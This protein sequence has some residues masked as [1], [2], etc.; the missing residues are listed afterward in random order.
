MNRFDMAALT[1]DEKP[2]RVNLA[3]N[4]AEK[5]K[6]L[7][8]LNQNMK[9]LDF[10]CGT[11]LLSFFLQPY[12]GEITGID[13]SKGMIEVFDKKIKEN[14]IKNM[15]CFNLDIHTDKLPEKYDLIVSSMVFH[16]IK[17]VSQILKILYGYLNEGGYIAIADLVKED[18]SF[19]D[20]NEGVEHFGFEIQEMENKLKEVGF[21]EIKSEIAHIVKK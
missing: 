19:H 12:V 18:G 14:Q 21:K 7:V 17:D 15:K 10:G 8:P 11:G 5:I 1:W 6:E 3:K 4:V 2:A 20:D 9:V 13:T 16:H